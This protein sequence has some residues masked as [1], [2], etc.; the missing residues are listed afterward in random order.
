MVPE[1]WDSEKFAANMMRPIKKL[2]RRQW[3][4]DWLPIVALAVSVVSLIVSVIALAK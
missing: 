4:T 1:D 3:R 2:Q